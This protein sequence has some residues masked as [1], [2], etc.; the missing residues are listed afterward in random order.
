MK[1]RE[2]M[3]MKLAR[4]KADTAIRSHVEVA[5]IMTEAGYPMGARNVQLTERR[6]FYKLFV[7]LA[8]ELEGAA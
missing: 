6:A 8:D 7:L 2:K 3:Q 4:P 1:P 5:R